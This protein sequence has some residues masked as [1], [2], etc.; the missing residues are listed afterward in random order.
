MSLLYCLTQSLPYSN[1][2]EYFSN[3]ELN[4]YQNSYQ[5]PNYDPIYW[6]FFANSVNDIQSYKRQTAQKWIANELNVKNTLKKYEIIM[7]SVETG[8]TNGS[9]NTLDLSPDFDKLVKYSIS[10]L[11]M[12]FQL[13]A[14]HLEMFMEFK[15]ICNV[16]ISE[17]IM[18]YKERTGFY[19]ISNILKIYFLNL[20]QN[21]EES[22][23]LLVKF[24]YKFVEDIPNFSYAN[25]SIDGSFD[26]SNFFCKFYLFHLI[27]GITESRSETANETQRKITFMSCIKHHING[28]KI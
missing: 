15:R 8:I 6:K 25:Y 5:N 21:I 23:K 11:T 1:L 4:N 9:L 28:L 2:Y 3:Q 16:S 7:N 12:S 27:L 13:F 20:V 14:I 24:I 17:D 26:R 22:E 19:F 18:I 10:C